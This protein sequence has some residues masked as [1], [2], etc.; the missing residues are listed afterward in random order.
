M[1]KLENEL[2]RGKTKLLFRLRGLNMAVEWQ[3][4]IPLVGSWRSQMIDWYVNDSQ[5]YIGTGGVDKIELRYI[6][7]CVTTR[8]KV[9]LN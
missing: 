1:K 3:G 6:Y 5:L 2:R 8:Q 7:I 4:S 9:I